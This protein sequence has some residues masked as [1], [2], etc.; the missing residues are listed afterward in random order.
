[1]RAVWVMETNASE[2]SPGKWVPDSR[3]GVYPSREEA[4]S[5]DVCVG[6]PGWRVV[7]YVPAPTKKPAKKKGA[8]R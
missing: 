2:E 4:E 7:K 8:G 5:R 6:E 1:M 3:N